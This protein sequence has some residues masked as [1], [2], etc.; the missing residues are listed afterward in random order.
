M[1][2]KSVGAGLY[3]YRLQCGT[4]TETRKMLL[5]DGGNGI[6]TGAV[7]IM[8]PAKTEKVA[9][10]GESEYK[11]TVT[12]DGYQPCFR[13]GVYIIVDADEIIDFITCS[14]DVYEIHGIP[15]VSI[16]GGTFRMGDIQNYNR[17]DQEKPVHE[18]I[19]SSVEMCIYEITNAQYAAYLNSAKTSGDITH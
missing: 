3:L 14:S 4:R 19:L 2:V 12:K 5:I 11:I 8:R 16:P 9:V 6:T 13:H 1:T 18:V 17:Y 7:P 10:I 15:F